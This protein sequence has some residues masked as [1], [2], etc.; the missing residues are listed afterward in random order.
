MRIYI[1]LGGTLFALFSCGKKDMAHPV[2]TK[3][4]MASLLVDI[5]LAEAQAQSVP[6]PQDSLIKIFLP[7]E[8][9]VLEAHHVSDS[10]L[11]DTYSYYYAHPKEL[12]AV[13]DA[14][15]DTLSLYEQRSYGKR[16][17]HPE[18]SPKKMKVE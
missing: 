10:L 1:L 6:K 8:K 15:I 2:L 18:P 17:T 5:Y 12:E 3:A 11:R 9:K 16:Y 13:Y 7:H 14:V 4:Q